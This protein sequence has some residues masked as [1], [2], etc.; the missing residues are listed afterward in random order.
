MRPVLGAFLLV[1]TI[2]AFVAESPA[3]SEGAAAGWRKYEGNP[4]LG[5]G[6]GTCFDVALL[7]DDGMY[8]MWFSWRPKESVALVESPDGIHWNEPQIVL[9]AIPQ[10]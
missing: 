1:M 5:G 4:V 2:A 7:R 6:L 3:G 9:A 8:R 10:G